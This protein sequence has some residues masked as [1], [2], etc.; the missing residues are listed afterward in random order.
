MSGGAAHRTTNPVLG[1]GGGVSKPHRATPIT[2]SVFIMATV[3][4]NVFAKAASTVAASTVAFKDA[5]VASDNASTPFARSVLAAVVGGLSS[6]DMVQSLIIAAFGSPISDKTGK[7]IAKVSGLRDVTGGARVYQAWKDIAYVVDNLD[8]DAP[9]EHTK[10]E[11]DE[12]ETVTIGNGAIRATV[13]AFI[14]Q[15]DGAVSALFGRTGLTATIKALVADHAK[16]IMALHG[17]EAD[18][19]ED[20]GKD[21]GKDEAPRQSLTDRANAMLVALRDADDATLTEASD[22]L[23]LLAD[24]IDQRFR[25]VEE[26]QETEART[27]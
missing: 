18:K 17:V 9:V 22:A 3:A 16:A 15:D 2:E 7:A 11:G 27:A 13:T 1:N 12:A 23:A 26:T 19:S 10:G 14:L 25:P 20:E 24:Y 21:E 6:V 4:V 8:A 5:S